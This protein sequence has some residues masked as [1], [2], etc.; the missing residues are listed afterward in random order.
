LV[1]SHTQLHCLVHH[2]IISHVKNFRVVGISK[3]CLCS[4]PI[5]LTFKMHICLTY[6][7]FSRL[8]D[9]VT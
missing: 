6:G 2:I 1:K 9:Q 8:C 4:L 5:T 7:S 3:G